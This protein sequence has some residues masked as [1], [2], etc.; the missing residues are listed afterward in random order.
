MARKAK[1]PRIV[2]LIPAR[3]GSRRIKQKNIR[4]LNHH[5]VSAYT[6]SSAFSSG[7]FTDIVVSTDSQQYADI[8]EYYGAE[9]P[10]LRPAEMATATS[11]DIE[12]IAFT[13]K[14]LHDS[15]RNYDCFAILRPTSPLRRATT[16]IRA[17]SQFLAEEKVDSLRAVEPC[18]QHPG[19]M[20]IVN[21][22]RMVPL[23]DQPL[24]GPPFHS[25]QY[26]TL[27][28]I[29]IQNA[30]L[31][32]SWSRTVLEQNSISGDVI[33][34]F[35]TTDNEGEDLNDEQDWAHIER[36]IKSAPKLLPEID[37]YPFPK[38]I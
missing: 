25:Q 24:E 11:P 35:L 4:R 5:P 3:S 16:I 27:P 20:W 10:F 37:K 32:I 31:E 17:W 26:A 19:K 29:Y 2:A 34:P 18:K 33:M 9:V 13:L 6:I 28:S 38:V 23:L 1:T 12:W 30:S 14:K 21:N 8:A 36:L 22:D 7:I 15:G